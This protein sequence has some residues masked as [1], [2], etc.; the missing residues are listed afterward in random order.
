MTT[1]N[2]QNASSFITTTVVAT[3]SVLVGATV[4]QKIRNVDSV[5]FKSEFPKIK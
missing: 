4:P 5:K 1:F 2:Q 3:A